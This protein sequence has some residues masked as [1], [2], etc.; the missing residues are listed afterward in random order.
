MC[1]AVHTF[2]VNNHGKKEKKKKKKKV[3]RILRPDVDTKRSTLRWH[4]LSQLAVQGF[5]M[6]NTMWNWQFDIQDPLA[7]EE[8][9]IISL[10][11]KSVV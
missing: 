6:I 1:T 3:K 7:R 9:L 11:R 5:K 10:D 4:S 8:P 2:L